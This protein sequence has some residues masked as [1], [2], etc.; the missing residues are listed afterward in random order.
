MNERSKRVTA[1]N[2]GKFF[3]RRSFEPENLQKLIHSMLNPKKYGPIPALEYGKDTEPIAR[4]DYVKHT[5]NTVEETGFWVHTEYAWMGGSPDGIVTD[6]TTGQKGLLEIK[7]PFSARNMT[8]DE[9]IN[10]KGSYLKRVGDLVIL[11]KSHNYFHQMQ[12][13]LFILQMPWCDFCVRT[14]KGIFV[15]RISRNDQFISS[16]MKRL[17]EFYVRFLL[18]SLATSSFKQ[19]PIEYKMLSKEVYESS[20]KNIVQT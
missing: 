1:S 9:Y 5:G 16:M 4:D 15:E 7:C 3:K 6:K 17:A 12:G 13:C 10:K 14:D 8:I 19:S 18:P 20:F 11:D 2:F